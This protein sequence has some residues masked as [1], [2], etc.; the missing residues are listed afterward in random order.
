VRH[1]R[2]VVGVV[3]TVLVTPR[4][5]ALAQSGSAATSADAP[6][7]KE[8]IWPFTV[9]LE[10]GVLDSENPDSRRA[11]ANWLRGHASET[12]AHLMAHPDRFFDYFASYQWQ[13]STYLTFKVLGETAVSSLV[14]LLKSDDAVT[15]RAA[16]KCLAYLGRD[17]AAAVRPL[18]DVLGDPALEGYESS[19]LVGTEE[20]AL[21]GLV[22]LLR[23]P[24][25]SQRLRAC[26][27]LGYRLEPTSRFAIYQGIVPPEFGPML[28][29]LAKETRDLS[30][31]GT[32]VN[33]GLITDDL[34]RLLVEECDRNGAR[35]TLS[36]DDSSRREQSVILLGALG[37][38]ASAA[39]PTLK[40][41]LATEQRSRYVA[42]EAD[43]L[44]RIAGSSESKIVLERLLHVVRGDD[45]S[46]EEAALPTLATM[47]STAAAAIPVLRELLAR[48]YVPS[49]SSIA[50]T[51]SQLGDP[52]GKQ[53]L[54]A[55]LDDP[56]ECMI[57]VDE[58]A[59]LGPSA[60]EMVPSLKRLLTY[61][62]P[63]WAYQSWRVRKAAAEALGAIGPPAASSLDALKEA[64]NDAIPPV[65]NAAAEAI[66]K[67]EAR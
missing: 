25:K 58:V 30:V 3:L 51:L 33:S 5:I 9:S 64:A 47:G 12:V 32:L 36:P 54:R 59:P 65:R 45:G 27:V 38:R 46:F 26:K 6:V 53:I 37:P 44:W 57:A 4:H 28:L 22:E 31:L 21:P 29:D 19:A 56:R 41:V 16:A 2:V 52:M 11:A 60:V 66:R 67:I 49:R 43:T 23:K 34:V 63:K 18:I 7:P 50:A 61:Y 62:D 17:A 15:R 20:R 55:M 14:P 40:S 13:D 1:G 24:E 42:R 8:R 35:G 10:I 39:V 48:N